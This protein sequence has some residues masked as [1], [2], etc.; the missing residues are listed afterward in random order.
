MLTTS[1]VRARRTWILSIIALLAIFTRSVS[2]RGLSGSTAAIYFDRKVRFAYGG[3]GV[4]E[5]WSW[6]KLLKILISSDR[7]SPYR[8]SRHRQQM[9]LLSRIL[10]MS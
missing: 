6:V 3:A 5:A 8:G 2:A 4:P 9:L 1:I 7:L 10:A